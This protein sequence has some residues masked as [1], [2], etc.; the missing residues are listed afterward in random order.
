MVTNTPLIDTA[1]NHG[2]T[3]IEL[4]AF[5]FSVYLERTVASSTDSSILPPLSDPILNHLS[6][7]A[8]F[9]GT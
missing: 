7:Y 3:S 5:Y 8:A 4:N 9:P 2:G 6:V 1:W